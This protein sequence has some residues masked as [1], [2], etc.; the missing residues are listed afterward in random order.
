MQGGQPEETLKPSASQPVLQ[1][2]Q[3]TDRDT[4]NLSDN[5][6]VVESSALRLR[7]QLERYKDRLS[8]PFAV[9][10]GGDRTVLSQI[11]GHDNSGLLLGGSS[12]GQAVTHRNAKEYGS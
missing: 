4:L 6:F 11:S 8:G 12:I 5:S 7:G 2:K 3:R 9:L 1:D 10:G